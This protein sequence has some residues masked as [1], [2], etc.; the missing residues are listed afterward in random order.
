MDASP[1]EVG[2]PWP[3]GREASASASSSP[4]DGMLDPLVDWLYERNL[5]PPIAGIPFA[6]LI[7]AVSWDSFP[8]DQLLFWLVLKL[9]TS[10]ARVTLGLAYR[11]RRPWRPR[12]VWARWQVACLGMDAL[13]WGLLGVW[14]ASLD[15]VPESAVIGATLIGIA[16]LHSGILSSHF[17]ANAA[18][19]ACLLVP[20]AL[21]GL[22]LGDRLG[23]FTAVGLFTLVALLLVTGRRAARSS[24]DLLR[25]RFELDRALEL[26][27]RQS[28][29][30]SQFLATMSHEMR[31][32]LHGILG[33]VR[34]LQQ[35]VRDD[36]QLD[37][38]ALVERS[39]EHLLGVINDVLDFSRIEAGRLAIRERPYDLARTVRDAV[40]LFT[41]A[42]H[43]GSLRI[44]LELDLPRPCWIEGD[45]IRVRQI[46]LNLVGNAV[47]FTE[48]GEVRVTAS[49]AG[50][51]VRFVV[52]DTG[53]GISAE[54][55]PHI[56]APFH[57]GDSS[58][59]RKFSGTGL[60]LAIS[61]E[62]ARA[63]GGDLSYAS[64][65]V[66][67]AI[68]TLDLPWRPAPEPEPAGGRPAPLPRLSGRVLLAEDNA[69][70]VI[71]ARAALEKMGL[72]I[73][74]A[75][76]GE[77]AVAGC[78]AAPPDVVLMDCHMPGVDGFEATRRIRAEEQARGR[79]RTPIIA[80]TA[81]ALADDRQ[82]SLDAGMDDVLAK[83]FTAE[84][85]GAV[86]QHYL[87]ASGEPAADPGS[88]PPIAFV[89]AGDALARFGGNHELYH[90]VLAGFAAGYG[91]AV[92]ALEDE[93]ARGGNDDALRRA[94]T[95]KG[96]AGT[97]GALPLEDAARR[98]EAAIR[99]GASRA[100]LDACLV[101]TA[102]ELRRAIEDC[103]R[104]TAP[105]EGA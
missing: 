5:A 67:G 98:L 15:Q 11:W 101:A 53:P 4:Q 60:G 33:T 69:L 86:L 28:A 51:R 83:P 47:K 81:S 95:L 58:Y 7:A 2:S 54:D 105:R 90:Q 40:A 23:T 27:H 103:A 50:D 62:L 3:A 64:A 89:G 42:A 79:G 73:T 17:P 77:Q 99:D 76:D 71:V 21:R 24:Q 32:P 35:R 34:L 9:M 10:V 16:A 88:P 72:L 31:T 82:R 49:L 45:G 100:D 68:F 61:R 74:L 20:T 97:V 87:P 48:R 19:T 75:A 96:L 1:P 57:Q 13:V 85:L 46:L 55:Q 102:G 63:M 29:V 94:H 93:L 8:R 38:L 70:N 52:A 92:Q 26:A 12:A 104:V 80:V 14:F 59:S 22:Y 39:G 30:K 36:E 18:F 78:R 91:G 25:L 84:S 65:P 44:D 56:F 37:H 6:V 41:A 43:A 66:R